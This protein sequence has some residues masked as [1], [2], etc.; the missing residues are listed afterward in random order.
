MLARC[1][2]G[3]RPCRGLAEQAG[4]RLS[5]QG[6]RQLGQGGCRAGLGGCWSGLAVGQ[7]RLGG[8]RLSPVD[9]GHA[10]L[11]ASGP[12]DAVHAELVLQGQPVPAPGSLLRCWG[13]CGRTWDPGIKASLPCSPCSRGGLLGRWLRRRA[14]QGLEQLHGGLPGECGSCCRRLGELDIVQY[15]IQLHLDWA[16]TSWL[17]FGRPRLAGGCQGLLGGCWTGLAGWGGRAW[18]LCKRCWLFG[19]LGK[20]GGW[21]SLP[22]PRPRLPDC[23]RLAGR[24]G[25]IPALLT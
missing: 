20:P 23:L 6:G 1:W 16:G 4:R 11:A 25:C 24:A 22:G 17:S 15:V 18:R 2:E 10:D 19:R 5:L 13:C 21:R 12:V 7:L 3:C 9:V 8:V 14:R